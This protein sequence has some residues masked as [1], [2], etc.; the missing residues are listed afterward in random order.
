VELG[1]GSLAGVA[2]GGGLAYA[3]TQPAALDEVPAGAPVDLALGRLEAEALREG[4][5]VGWA[6]G[7]PVTLERLAAW[8]GTLPGKGL[9]LVPVSALMSEGGTGSG[10]GTGAG[11]GTGGGRGAAPPAETA[12]SR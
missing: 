11:S 8:A 9:R 2:A 5:A 12:A 10:A 1:G 4:A 7:Y 3:A 6:R